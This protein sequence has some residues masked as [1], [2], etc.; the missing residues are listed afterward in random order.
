ME[1][2]NSDAGLYMVVSIFAILIVIG[3]FIRLCA[4]M[5]DFVSE[6]RYINSEIRRTDGAERRYWIRKR[7][8]LWLSLIPFVRY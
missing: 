7:R 3:L 1:A 5:E 2:S 8:R 6:L 4:F